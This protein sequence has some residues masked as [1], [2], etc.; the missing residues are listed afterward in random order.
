M[1]PLD[2][3]HAI[4]IGHCVFG[5]MP[6]QL[7]VVGDS[8]DAAAQILCDA[9][10]R[11]KGVTAAKI[12]TLARTF[13]TSKGNSVVA[14]AKILHFIAPSLY[15]IWDKHVARQWGASPNGK[16]AGDEYVKFSKA[17][18]AAIELPD[19]G[20]ACTIMRDHLSRAGFVGEI[21]DLRAAELIIFQGPR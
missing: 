20:E 15:P 19:G 6:T 2:R 4:L 3:H 14:A 7:T 21:T 5:W 17:L 9:E 12:R 13:Q 1:R 10:T 8:I 16:K 18:R 11:P